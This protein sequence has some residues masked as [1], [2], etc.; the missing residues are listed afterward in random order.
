MALSEKELFE[1]D[2]KRDIGEELLQAIQNV[3]AGKVGRTFSVAVP[4]IVEA[5]QKAG[6]S[7]SEFARILGVSVRTLQGWEQGRRTPSG[8]ARSLIK[9]A[10]AKPEL[11][12][13]ALSA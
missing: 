3:K 11:L 4:P 6:F 7:Q 13:E 1:R 8:A 10:G 9:I 5:R 2:A 12:K